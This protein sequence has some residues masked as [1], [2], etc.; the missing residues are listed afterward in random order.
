MR[1][2]RPWVLLLVLLLMQIGQAVPRLHTLVHSHGEVDTLSHAQVEDPH[3]AAPVSQQH[4]HT[5]VASG[6]CED[7]TRA[8]VAQPET[9]DS[10]IHK[11][12]RH[13]EAEPLTKG[14]DQI[15]AGFCHLAHAPPDSEPARAPPANLL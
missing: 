4:S 3:L 10:D 12:V 1:P 7:Y 5:I 8:A 2:V 11:V 14:Q 6:G 9:F 15:K 13:S